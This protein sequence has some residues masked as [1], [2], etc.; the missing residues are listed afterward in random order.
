[1]GKPTTYAEAIDWYVGLADDDPV[2][3]EFEAFVYTIAARAAWRHADLLH[4]AE[5]RRSH[6]EPT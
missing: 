1:M 3:H 5:R 6:H 2:K 4:A